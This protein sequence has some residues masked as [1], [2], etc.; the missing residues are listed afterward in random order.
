MLGFF[1]GIYFTGAVIAFIIAFFATM[2]DGVNGGGPNAFGVIL[3]SFVVS[4]IYPL[5]LIYLLIKKIFK[6]S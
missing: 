6:K 4:I 2:L 5:I 3:I 1:L